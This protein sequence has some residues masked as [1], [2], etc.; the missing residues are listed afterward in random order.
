[1]RSNKGNRR[2]QCIKFKCHP[3]KRSNVTKVMLS[4]KNGPATCAQLPRTP[5]APAMALCWN[6]RPSSQQAL[7]ESLAQDTLGDRFATSHILRS[8]RW[9]RQCGHAMIEGHLLET[10]VRSLGWEESPAAENSNPFQDSCLEN[11]M[12]RGAWWALVH[13]VAKSWTRLSTHPFPPGPHSCH[14]A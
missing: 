12:D 4:P 3:L 10:W 13:G 9:L 11:P 6:T 14:S 8:H 2:H 7:L 1:M 5:A